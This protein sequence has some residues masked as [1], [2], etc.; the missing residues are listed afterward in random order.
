[1]PWMW[2]LTSHVGAAVAPDSTGEFE[3]AARK[4]SVV[5]CL[6]SASY[7]GT[8]LLGLLIGVFGGR[9]LSKGFLDALGGWLKAER[10]IWYPRLIDSGSGLRHL[11]YAHSSLVL[12]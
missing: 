1:M 12:S 4:S 11:Q 8:R 10:A 2:K 6:R 3:V 9:L 5:R 7:A